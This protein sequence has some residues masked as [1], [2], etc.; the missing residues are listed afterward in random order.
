LGKIPGFLFDSIPRSPRAEFNPFKIESRPESSKSGAGVPEQRKMRK[1]KG[2]KGEKG[3][4][5]RKG[6]KE[7]RRK[8]E[9]KS[10]FHFL[11]LFQKDL[12]NRRMKPRKM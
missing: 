5:G 8:K 6:R 9:K 1:E 3:R 10:Y 2:E 11:E 4:K 12:R 7:E